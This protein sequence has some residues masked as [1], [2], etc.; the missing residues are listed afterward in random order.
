MAKAAK[1][2]QFVVVMAHEHGERIPL[3]IADFDAARGTI[4]LSLSGITIN[5]PVDTYNTAVS[6]GRSPDGTRTLSSSTR[7]I[8][9]WSRTRS[10][11]EMW[12]RTPLRGSM[13]ATER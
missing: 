11:P 7:Q 9:C 3:T 13:P 8:P 5:A 6:T 2:G 1:P 4:T 10:M 12:T